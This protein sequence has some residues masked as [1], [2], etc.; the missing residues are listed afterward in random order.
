MH[1]YDPDGALLTPE[2]TFEAG[3]TYQ[4]EIKL[5]VVTLDGVLFV[6]FD[7]NPN[8]T[9]NGKTIDAENVMVGNSAPPPTSTLTMSANR[10][11]SR[12]I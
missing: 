11:H 7:S 8:V 4:V 3:K 1:W 9:L 2:D 5:T 10:M 12:A 6:K